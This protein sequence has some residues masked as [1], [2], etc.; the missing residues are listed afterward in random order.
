L[1]LVDINLEDICTVCPDS[2]ESRTSNCG[3]RILLLMVE[4]ARLMA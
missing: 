3:K 4:T 2:T 1:T